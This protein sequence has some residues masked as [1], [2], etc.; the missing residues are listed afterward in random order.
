[1]ATQRDRRPFPAGARLVPPGADIAPED[2]LSERR[3]TPDGS[4][5]VT[6]PRS[7]RWVEFHSAWHR[8]LLMDT[9]S[10]G[11]S[12]LLTAGMHETGM[13]GH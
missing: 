4:R 9:P 2:D 8:T 6:S 1:M 12:C 11:G 3:P 5:G 13:A 10:P 7:K